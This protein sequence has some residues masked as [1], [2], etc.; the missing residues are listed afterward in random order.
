V[1]GQAGCGQD[2]DPA[3]ERIGVLVAYEHRATRQ[4]EHGAAERDGSGTAR[5]S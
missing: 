4:Y 5:P 2:V 1:S 3:V